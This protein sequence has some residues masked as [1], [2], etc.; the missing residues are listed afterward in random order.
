MP[1][2]ALWLLQIPEIVALLETFDV[3]VVDRAIIERRFGLRCRRA[4]K[5]L[6]RFGGYQAGRTVFPETLRQG[7]GTRTASISLTAP[8][9]VPR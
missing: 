1:S 8:R 9:A 7:L 6:H 2:K 5:L 4:I 3:P